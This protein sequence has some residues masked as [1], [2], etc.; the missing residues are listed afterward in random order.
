MV[1]IMTQQMTFRTDTY[2]SPFYRLVI[3]LPAPAHTQVNV[4]NTKATYAFHVFLSG[5]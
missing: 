1:C 3:G 2:L 5:A 4:E